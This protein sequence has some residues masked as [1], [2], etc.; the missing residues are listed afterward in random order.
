MKKYT[1]KEI[2]ELAEKIWGL[3]INNKLKKDIFDLI[4][5][6]ITEIDGKYNTKYRSEKAKDIKDVKLLHHEHTISRKKLKEGLIH[7]KNIND[8]RK[9]LRKAEGCVI[10]R[11]EHMKL[12]HK[13]E[14]RKKYRDVG[15]KLIKMK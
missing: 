12:N 8:V 11:E 5:W 2:Y 13:L 14:G 7:A 6:R 3:D 4:I 1:L 15:I 10:L 9:I